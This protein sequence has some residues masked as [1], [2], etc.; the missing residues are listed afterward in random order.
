VRKGK[1]DEGRDTFMVQ[2]AS[3]RA[4]ALANG[5]PAS[6][7]ALFVYD[8]V[9]IANLEAEFFTRAQLTMLSE[10][11]AQKGAGLLVFGG[12]SF[13]QRGFAGTA[14]ETV[15]PLELGDRRGG[16]LRVPFDVDRSRPPLT[17]IVTPEGASHPVM[18]IGGSAAAS[19]ELWSELPPLAASAALGGPRPGATVLAVTTVASGGVYP[20]VAVQRYG[21]GRSMAFTGEASWRWRMMRPSS[22][23]AHEFFW[24][25]SARWIAAAAQEPVTIALPDAVEPGEGVEITLEARDR[26]FAPAADAVAS[27]T[28][29]PPGG[30]PGE[31]TLRRAGGAGRFSGTLRPETAGLYRIHA[32]ARRGPQA[33]GSVDQWFYAG[34]ADREFA[35]PR[36]NE[37]VLRRLARETGG[38]Y[39]R[40]ADAGQVTSW[41]EAAVPQAIEPERRDLWHE[42][43]AFLLVVGVL[44]A[45][46]TLRRR[47]GLR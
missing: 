33:L 41:L 29:T 34:G 9:I 8:A 11:V 18:R 16:L 5:F 17:A 21:R 10:L 46:W 36:L 25:Q 12:R 28:L 4:A 42:P 1:N 15:L 7:E 30:A 27:A 45:E 39:V 31:L 2:A 32:E 19:A 3:G 22:D 40:R 35:D 47:W 43:W 20:L 44:A 23:R 26:S 38:R 6:R 14:L 24:R 13:A 37:A